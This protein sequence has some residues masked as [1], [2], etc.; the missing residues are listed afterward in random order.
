MTG[1]MADDRGNDQGNEI[2]TRTGIRGEDIIHTETIEGDDNRIPATP[3][4]LGISKSN[5][6]PDS[7]L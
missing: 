7:I 5:F 3:I 1:V 2:E 4:N 6:Y